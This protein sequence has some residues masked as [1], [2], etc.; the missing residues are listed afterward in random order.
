MAQYH[1]LDDSGDPG[2][3]D[4]GSSSHFALA[5]VQM[6]ERVPLPELA[7]LRRMFH[8]P[9]MFEFK[10]YRAKPRQKEAFF[11]MIHPLSFRVRAVVI[12]KSRLGNQFAGMSGQD[13]TIEFIAGLTLRAEQLDLANDMLVVDGAML[14]FLRSLRIRLSDECH[15]LG[16]VRPFRKIISGD[17]K[18]DDGLQ[19]ADMV[20]GAIRHYVM[21]EE[22]AYYRTFA[23]KVVDLWEAP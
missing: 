7:A 9:P 22:T 2:L 10:Y 17:S 3:G 14:G 12:D 21:G 8:L 20:V 18:R 1:L 13:L 15:K 19:L 11:R 16:R 5:M 6:P 23:P 4:P